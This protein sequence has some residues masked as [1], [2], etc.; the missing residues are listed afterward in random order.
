MFC[1]FSF[2]CISYHALLYVQ[3][4][5]LNLFS[6]LVLYYCFPFGY[7]MM[8]STPRG[9]PGLVLKV[10]DTLCVPSSLQVQ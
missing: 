3:R 1:F 10:G 9:V 8:V 5:I 2:F 7:G 4:C 6:I